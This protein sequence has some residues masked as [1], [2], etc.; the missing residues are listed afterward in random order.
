MV[1]SRNAEGKRRFEREERNMLPLS[2]LKL[3]AS[4]QSALAMNDR[5]APQVSR[6]GVIYIETLAQT[7]G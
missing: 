2:L 1:A 5:M 6:R 7:I 4:E 3:G